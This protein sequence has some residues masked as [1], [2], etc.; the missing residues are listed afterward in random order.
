MGDETPESTEISA[1]TSPAV[2]ASSPEAVEP[3]TVAVPQ[4]SATPP[5]PPA[6]EAA[7]TAT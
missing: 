4:V 6:S 7:R 2:S 1:A 3:A 5:V